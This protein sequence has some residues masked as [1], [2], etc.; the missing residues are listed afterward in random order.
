LKVSV[1]ATVTTL[2]INSSLLP[3][4]AFNPVSAPTF[5]GMVDTYEGL[6]LAVLKLFHHFKWSHVSLLTDSTAVS[7]SY[8][9]M[10]AAIKSSVMI[11]ENTMKFRI[12]DLNFSPTN[13][14]M[15]NAFKLASQQSRGMTLCY[16]KNFRDVF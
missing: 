5:I 14:S 15:S 10:K 4:T 3:E 11:N 8:K 16:Q 2:F 7:E 6:S 9:Y 1:I 13:S 12:N